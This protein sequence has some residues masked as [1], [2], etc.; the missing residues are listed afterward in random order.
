MTLFAFFLHRLSQTKRGIQTTDFQRCFS[1]ST[2]TFLWGLCGINDLRLFEFSGHTGDT[3]VWAHEEKNTAHEKNTWESFTV[4]GGITADKQGVSGDLVPLAR[5]CASPKLPHRNDDLV[6]GVCHSRK[7]PGQPCL[8]AKRHRWILPLGLVCFSLREQWCCR[9]KV[10]ALAFQL[11]LLWRWNMVQQDANPNARTH[12]GGD[13]WG[14]DVS[15]TEDVQLWEAQKQ[16]S[17]RLIVLGLPVF[18][19]LQCAHCFSFIDI[20]ISWR[21]KQSPVELIFQ[22]KKTNH[23]FSG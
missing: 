9:C 1:N 4:G 15:G 22:W 10:L 21:R 2:A 5:S 20:N 16:L 14:T 3:F 7:S 19:C 11:V 12:S 17:L 8:R 13:Y 23:N 6:L 18:I